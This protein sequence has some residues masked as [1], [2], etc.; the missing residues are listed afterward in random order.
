MT[1]FVILSRT[2]FTVARSASFSNASYLTICAEP[3]QMKLW[4]YFYITLL[5]CSKFW[6]LNLD[7]ECAHRPNFV[8]FGISSN[9]HTVQMFDIS[10]LYISYIYFHLKI[11]SHCC[12]LAR[13]HIIWGLFRVIGNTEPTTKMMKCQLERSHEKSF[14]QTKLLARGGGGGYA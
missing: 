13:S 1:L 8:Y 7:V 10:A 11:G 14:V 12:N 3:S 5:G 2:C 6:I 9:A 4:K